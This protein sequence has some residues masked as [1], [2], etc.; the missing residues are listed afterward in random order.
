MTA[1]GKNDCELLDTILDCMVKDRAVMFI[2]GLITLLPACL[3][4]FL[5][6]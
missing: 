6:A 2:S 1:I 4:S 3:R 5:N